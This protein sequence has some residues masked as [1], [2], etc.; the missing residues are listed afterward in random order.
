MH[1]Q[2]S[3]ASRR[4]LLGWGKSFFGPHSAPKSDVAP[5]TTASDDVQSSASTKAGGTR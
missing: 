5:R 1:A 4:G 2:S 3:I